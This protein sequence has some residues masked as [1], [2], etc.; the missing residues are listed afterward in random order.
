M[1]AW[2][3]LQK[4][5]GGDERNFLAPLMR[6][7]PRREGGHIAYQKNDHGA[8]YRP[9]GLRGGREI[10]IREIFEAVRFSTFAT[11]SVEYRKWSANGQNDTIEPKRACR[12][13]TIQ[14]SARE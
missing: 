10:I 6:F 7:V 3:L 12:Q 1:S 11:L 14:R 13:P 9:A 4:S 5:F 8:S 2:L